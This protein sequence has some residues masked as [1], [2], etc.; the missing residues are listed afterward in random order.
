MVSVMRFSADKLREAR[1]AM[2]EHGRPVSQERLAELLGVSKR[3]VERWETGATPRRRQIEQ[4][5]EV[6]GKPEGFF[7][8]G[9]TALSVSDREVVA[10]ALEEFKAL[11]DEAF[12]AALSGVRAKVAA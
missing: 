10:V 4:I 2:L 12:T 3:S 7:F 9:A 8:I 1:Q 11:L 5:A 6:T